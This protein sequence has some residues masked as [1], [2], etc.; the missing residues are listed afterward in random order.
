MGRVIR[1]NGVLIDGNHVIIRGDER[2][3][4]EAV[5]VCGGAQE[6]EVTSKELW[7]DAIITDSLSRR[8]TGAVR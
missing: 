5:P 7:I 6:V 1:Q 3:A 8:S 4:A 2:R